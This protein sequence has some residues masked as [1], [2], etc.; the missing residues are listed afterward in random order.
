MDSWGWITVGALYKEKLTDGG[1]RRHKLRHLNLVEL[2]ADRHRFMDRAGQEG[3]MML[4]LRLLKLG[5]P[6][7]RNHRFI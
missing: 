1:R 7:L 6:I 4:I 3:F 2:V 5:L